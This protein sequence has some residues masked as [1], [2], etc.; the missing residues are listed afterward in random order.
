MTYISRFPNEDGIWTTWLLYENILYLEHGMHS[1][2]LVFL[3]LGK[4]DL[5]QK[6]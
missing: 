5:E 6:G 3:L 2:K 1:I 4:D